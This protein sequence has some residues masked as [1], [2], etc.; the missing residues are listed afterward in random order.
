VSGNLPDLVH[1]SEPLSLLLLV[2]GL[3]EPEQGAKQGPVA[4]DDRL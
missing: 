4:E 2:A 3:A 1:A